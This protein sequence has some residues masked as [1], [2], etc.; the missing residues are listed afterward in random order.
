MIQKD[1]LKPG[2]WISVNY[3]AGILLEARRIIETDIIE[4][5]DDG[6]L[7]ENG[8]AYTLIIVGNKWEYPKLPLKE[9]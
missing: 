3:L 1:N 5:G 4:T 7:I 9:F 2:N 6:V 8:G